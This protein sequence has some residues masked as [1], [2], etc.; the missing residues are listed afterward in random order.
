LYNYAMPAYSRGLHLQKAVGQTYTIHIPHR[1]TLGEKV[2]LVIL[3]HWGGKK[4][5]YMGRDMMEIFGLPAFSEMQA[6]L[7]APDR[8][9]QHWATEKAMNDL[10]KL[11]DYLDQHYNLDPNRRLV[12]GFSIGGVGVWYLGAEVPTL[13]SC[14][15]TIAAPIPEH[16]I[17][18]EWSFPIFTIY[19]R[20]DEVFPYD[21]NF[22][23]AQLMKE[24]GAPVEFETVENAMHTDLREYIGVFGKARNWVKG[25]WGES[26]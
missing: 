13:F 25:I 19:G 7:V 23:R 8:K 21:I 10:V 20:N 5:R 16:I 14:G 11:V 6:I 12:A 9:R 22:S 3:L 18:K 1:Y 24:K 26:N 17:D 15:I 2:P 4:Y